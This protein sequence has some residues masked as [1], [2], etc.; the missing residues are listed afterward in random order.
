[1]LLDLSRGFWSPLR[2]W[3]APLRFHWTT[4]LIALLIGLSSGGFSLFTL[5]ASL[6]AVGLLVSH[7]LGHAFL[8]RRLGHRVLSVDVFGFHGACRWHGYASPRDQ[9]IIAWG[10]VLAQA[11]LLV[12]VAIPLL[13]FGRQ[14]LLGWTAYQVFVQS[15][16]FL[17]ILNLL[18]FAPLDGAHAWT[19]LPELK[20]RFRRRKAPKAPPPPPR[21]RADLRLVPPLDDV[22]DTPLSEESRRIA[23]AAIREA[24]ERSKSKNG[25]PT[26]H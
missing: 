7:E 4:P 11:L 9:A 25:K 16:I 18:P 8:V 5:L 26:L 20:A 10:G 14:S 15:N 23:D 3:G 22:D 12:L 1:M 21:S 2:V 6:M 24:I 19:L 13:L 17:I